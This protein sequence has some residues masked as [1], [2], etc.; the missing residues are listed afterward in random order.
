[1]NDSAQSK[2]TSLSDSK[3]SSCA[4][5][6][7]ID[8][9]KHIL[10]DL[11]ARFLNHSCDPNVGV[12]GEETLNEWGAVDFVALKDIGVGEVCY[13]SIDE[14]NH[15]RSRGGAEFICF[16]FLSESS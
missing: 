7:Q 11:P 14:D 13:D 9:D 3:P 1:M 5:S 2:S 6:I 16:L 4:Y 8:S 12:K 15:F 10:L